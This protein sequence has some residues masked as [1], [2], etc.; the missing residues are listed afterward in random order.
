MTARASRRSWRTSLEMVQVFVTA[1]KT[2]PRQSEYDPVQSSLARWLYMQRHLARSQRLLPSRRAELDEQLVGWDSPRLVHD[3]SRSLDDE[4]PN[5]GLGA[6]VVRLS[7]DERFSRAHAFAVRTNQWPTTSRHASTAERLTAQWLLRQRHA[8]RAEKLSAARVRRLDE[9]LPGWNDS[10]Y[11]PHDLVVPESGVAGLIDR[12][13]AF[14]SSHRRFAHAISTDSHERE[15]ARWLQRHR[16]SLKAG[17]LD[18]AEAHEL[19]RR[20]PGW[21]ALTIDDTVFREFLQQTEELI[22]FLRRNGRL[23]SQRS[24][25]SDAEHHLASWLNTIRWRARQ[26]LLTDNQ[27]AV[28][29]EVCDDPPP[30]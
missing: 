15:L 26:G 11:P 4:R 1:R 5:P 2:W 13:E 20:L 14:V 28:L 16:A 17:R 29:E 9:A 3:G 19:S 6:P 24:S 25:A 23:P 27:R 22:L 30:R 18:D 21:D 8:W 12:Y 7:W 10:T